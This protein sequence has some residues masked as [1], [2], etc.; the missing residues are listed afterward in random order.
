MLEYEGIFIFMRQF[1]FKTYADDG[2]ISSHQSSTIYTLPI[3]TW[4]QTNYVFHNFDGSVVLC[5][6]EHRQAAT[7]IQRLECICQEFFPLTNYDFR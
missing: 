5:T 7:M 4:S 3:I 1:V 2:K 6:Y